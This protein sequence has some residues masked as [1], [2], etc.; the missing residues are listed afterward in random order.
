VVVLDHFGL[1]AEHEPEGPRQ[2]ADVE[3]LVVLV[4]HE[5][6]AVHLVPDG[7]GLRIRCSGLGRSVVSARPVCRSQGPSRRP[8]RPSSRAAC[9][10]LPR[11]TARR[12][13]PSRGR[14][15]AR[16]PE[17]SRRYT[18]SSVARLPAAPGAYGQPPVPPVAASKQRIPPARPATTLA[19]PSRGC[20]GSGTR[21]D[22]RDSGVDRPRGQRLDLG[23]NPDADRVAEADLVDAQLDQSQR[24]LDGSLR[25]TAPVYGHPNAVE[26]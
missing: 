16:R 18:R 12:R 9:R 22:R 21:S 23:R 3:R 10:A 5:H 25:G 24:D 4:Q 7:T 14:P 19:R 8:G 6:D 26:T 20:R 15:R 13:G 1:L 11:R 2:V 17:A